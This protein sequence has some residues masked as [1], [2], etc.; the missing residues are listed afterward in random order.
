MKDNSFY[1]QHDNTAFSDEKILDLRSS[2]GIEGYGIYW[3]LIE[4]LHQ[5]NGKMQLLSKRLAFAIQVNEQNLMSVINDFNLF[6]VEDGYFYSKRLLDQIQYRAEI[7]EKRS[8]AG[9]SGANAK[10]MLSKHSPKERK[11][12]ERKEEDNKGNESKLWRD[13]FEIYKSELRTIYKELVIDDEW[14]K[15]QERLNPGI[16]IL[17]TLEKSCVNYWATEGGWKHKKKSPKTTN[18]DWKATLTNS[19]SMPGNRVYKQ[20]KK[21]TPDL[22]D[23]RYQ[24][25]WNEDDQKQNF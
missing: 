23:T 7:I 21:F 10:Q 16:D 12:K 20:T 13:D 2:L 18:I 9:K 8:I 14:I 17:L 6:I 22:I 3:A 4:L 15:T 19:I 24:P 1:F 11:G 25:E 5:N